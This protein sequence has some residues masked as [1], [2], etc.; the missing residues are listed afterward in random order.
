LLAKGLAENPARWQYA[1]DIG[2]IHYWHTGDYA[3]AATWFERASEMPGAPDWIAPLAAA[4]LAEG[5]DRAGARQMLTEL[6]ASSESYIRD[7]A[8]RS[9]AQLD[10]LDLIDAIHVLIEQF[11]VLEGR[12]PR[13]WADMVQRGL[14]RDVPADPTGEPL[15]YDPVAHGARLSPSSA[16]APLPSTLG[17][18]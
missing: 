4:T 13:G 11:L 14:L 18:R 1:H 5:G 16:L 6:V 2:F 3:Q 9:L 12:Y 15:V 7:R 10:T 8:E 17:A